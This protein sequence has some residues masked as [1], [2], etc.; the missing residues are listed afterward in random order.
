MK[1][2]T[3]EAAAEQLAVSVKTIKNLLRSGKLRGVKVGNL[4]RLREEALEEYLK[5]S[6]HNNT[7]A[8]KQP[9]ASKSTTS[10]KLRTPL[11]RQLWKIRSRMIASGEPLLGWEEIEQEIAECRWG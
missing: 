5:D 1:L 10:R 8:T 6:A 7:L 9:I 4:W 2:L 11:G 3:P